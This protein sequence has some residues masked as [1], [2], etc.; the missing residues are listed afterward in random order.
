M[1][2]GSDSFDSLELKRLRDLIPFK[3]MG[4]V[5]EMINIYLATLYASK[6]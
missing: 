1:K 3:M 6:S 2:Y 5:Y 4:L